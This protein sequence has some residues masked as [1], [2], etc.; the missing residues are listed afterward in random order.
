[1]LLYDQTLNDS[2]HNRTKIRQA[3]IDIAP[4]PNEK[5]LSPD[6]IIGYVYKIEHK[7]G[8]VYI[9]QSKDYWARGAGHVRAVLSE[10]ITRRS[11]IDQAMKDD[12]IENFTMHKLWACTS[13]DELLDKEFEFICKY[14]STNPKDGYN[15]WAARDSFYGRYK[16]RNRNSLSASIES[17]K[18]KSR[19]VIAVN[20]ESKQF[21]ICASL[22]LLGTTVFGKTRDIMA[23]A[24]HAPHLINKFYILYYDIDIAQ[25]VLER[26]H[27]IYS[28]AKPGR[29]QCIKGRD[30]Q[31]K[32]LYE[33]VIKRDFSVFAEADFNFYEIDLSNEDPGFVL[34][35]LLYNFENGT[36]SYN[37]NLTHKFTYPIYKLT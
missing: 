25:E 24:A 9:G 29:G 17:R 20:L 36:F 11:K 4:A 8:L 6:S 13:L 15:I 3:F 5:D 27:R 28:N 35:S 23:H 30:E 37:E 2:L 14:N 32:L 7:S 31:F 18:A 33:L 19:R 22:K 1:M 21:F 12:G 26:Q 16:S 10:S 34:H